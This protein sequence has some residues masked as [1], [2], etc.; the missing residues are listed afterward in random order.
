MQKSFFN[1]LSYGKLT[2]LQFHKVPQTVHVLDPLDLDLSGF[3]RVLEA[4]TR[5]FQIKPL[6]EAV[7]ALRAGNLPPRTACITFDDGYPDW[8]NGV[9]PVLEKNNAHATFFITTGQFSGIPLWNERIL[10]AISHISD[11]TLSLTLGEDLKN[12]SVATF[13]VSRS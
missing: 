13:K 5:I 9:V 7:L 4:T 3:E 10:H 6:E 2:V 1:W 11:K 12:I 8:T